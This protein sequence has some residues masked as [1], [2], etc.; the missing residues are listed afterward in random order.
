MDKR[1][2]PV[3]AQKW[4]HVEEVMFSDCSVD[5]IH[6]RAFNYMLFFDN[7]YSFD[8]GVYALIPKERTAVSRT[9]RLNATG[10]PAFTSM[11][12]TIVSPRVRRSGMDQQSIQ[13]LGCMCPVFAT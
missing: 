4:G 5:G 13:K 7:F 10:Q 3:N 9:S 6:I 11:A 8:N 2:A 12:R 1:S